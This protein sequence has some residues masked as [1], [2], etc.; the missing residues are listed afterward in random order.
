V[1]M[2]RIKDVLNGDIDR[3]LLAHLERRAVEGGTATSAGGG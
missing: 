2:S 1:T 3:F